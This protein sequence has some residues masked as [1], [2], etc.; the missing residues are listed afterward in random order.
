VRVKFDDGTWAKAERRDDGEIDI[1]YPGV[2]GAP[3]GCINFT[4]DE[5]LVHFAQF[6]LKVYRKLPLS[7]YNR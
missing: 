3:D 2:D 5:Q 1:H 6:L 7:F 4:T